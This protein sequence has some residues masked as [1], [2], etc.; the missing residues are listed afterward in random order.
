VAAN[1]SILLLSTGVMSCICQWVL[2]EQ[3]YASLA[4]KRQKKIQNPKTVQT[5]S[6]VDMEETPVLNF[7]AKFSTS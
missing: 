3:Q 6:G 1:L 5:Q 7:I 4:G 2:Q